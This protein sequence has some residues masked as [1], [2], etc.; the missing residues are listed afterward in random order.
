MKASYSRLL[1]VTLLGFIS[2]PSRAQD[3]S[4]PPS[5]LTLGGFETQG[6]ATVGYRFTDIRG[7]QPM[8]LQLFDL[9]NGFRL[10]DF[11]L[12]GTAKEG[13]NPFADSFSLQTSGLGG[14]PFPTAQLTVTKHQLYDFRVNWRQSYYYWNQNDNVILPLGLPGLTTNHDWGTVRKFGSADLTLHASNNLRFNFDY[15]RTTNSGPV[16]TTRAPD[17]FSSPGFWGNYVRANPYYLY[18]PLDDNTNRFTGRVD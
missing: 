12:F 14:D 5:P 1:L 16:F 13:T 8:F 3:S 9:Q 11:D 2:L 17:F 4:K 18:A 6:S 10:H 15:Y 7:Y